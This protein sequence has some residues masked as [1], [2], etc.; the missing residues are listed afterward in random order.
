MVMTPDKSQGNG[1]EA[2]GAAPHERP[3]PRISIHAFC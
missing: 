2:F 3:V 1:D